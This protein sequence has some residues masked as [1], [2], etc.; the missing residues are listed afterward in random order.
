MDI[1]HTQP[2][3]LPRR[4]RFSVAATEVYETDWLASQPV[5]YNVKT[6]A[7]SHNV[8]DVIDYADLQFHPEGFRNF[9]EFGYSVFGQTPLRNIHFLQ[10]SSRLTVCDDGTLKIESLPDPVDNWLG[11]TTNEDELIDL[12]RHSIR[13]W[14]DSVDGD[15][16]IPHEWWL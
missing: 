9:L 4:H 2:A 5:F 16:I 14:E 1:G 13:E 3:G 11:R 6:R 12:I 7:V 10:H 15:I 8:N